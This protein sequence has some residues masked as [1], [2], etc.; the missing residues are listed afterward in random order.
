MTDA[1]TTLSDSPMNMVVEKVA[2]KLLH[3]LTLRIEPEPKDSGEVQV[4]LVGKC[5]L[6]LLIESVTK[7]CDRQTPDK[8]K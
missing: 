7:K 5:H 1:P 6:H 3:L 8:K 4:G 2:E